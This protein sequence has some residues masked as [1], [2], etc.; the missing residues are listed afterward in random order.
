MDWLRS[1]NSLWDKNMDIMDFIPAESTVL[2]VAKQAKTELHA[3][4]YP[5]KSEEDW[6]DWLNQHH[7]QPNAQNAT[8]IKLILGAR[9]DTGAFDPAVLSYLPFSEGTFQK[10]IKEFKIHGTIARTINR[11]T[12]CAFIRKFHCWDSPTERS[13]VYNCRSNASWEGDLGLSVTFTPRTMTTHAV[14]YGCDA[15][16]TEEIV[17]RLSGSDLPSLHPMVLVVLFAELERDRLD[18]LVRNKISRLIQQIIRISDN[19]NFTQ[20]TD[21]KTMP[22][23]SPSLATSIKDWLEMGDLRN[24]L[25][26]FK[27]KMC[28]MTEHIDEF[29]D[30][31]LNPKRDKSGF[32]ASLDPDTLE[33][34]RETGT[35]MKERLKHL[36]DE[37]DEHI[38]KCAN[39][40]EG[41]GLASQL[42]WNQI[43]RKD[44][45]TN[46][47]IA[48]NGLKVAQHTRR[49]SE[50]MKSI[51]LLT[52]VFL[53]A[54]FVA[55]LFSMGIFSWKGPRGEI[56]SVSPWIWLYV[57]VTVAI[58][59]V[60]LGTWYLWVMRRRRR[61]ASHNDDNDNNDKVEEDLEAQIQSAPS[62][63][64]TF[65]S[66]T[67]AFTQTS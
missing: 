5:L 51:A 10:L 3:Q 42:E 55:T 56:L 15:E 63:K 29:Q 54:T 22:P 28:D 64:G 1:D 23:L 33:G 7:H 49:D 16:T 60:T 53:P 59:S 14:M 18:R 44:T 9:A 21:D 67:T 39:I 6:E 26:A 13:L 11:N 19:N 17:R 40:I 24:G 4:D 58:T 46:L 31:L 45:F 36:I 48:H 20:T 66:S 27:R 37:F 34:L 12:S 2:V 65:R 62:E 8:T 47:Q 52:M 30:R 41:V 38:R 43:G 61:A 32:A 35:K 25:Q 50:L 57:A